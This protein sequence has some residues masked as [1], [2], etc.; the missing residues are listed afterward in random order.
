M[1]RTEQ[2]LGIASELSYARSTPALRGLA[3]SGRSGRLTWR[4]RDRF[5][6][7]VVY[8]H[9]TGEH[10]ESLT[11]QLLFRRSCF[12][13]S[14]PPFGKQRPSAIRRTP[15]ERRETSQ[16]TQ[17]RRV[18]SSFGWIRCSGPFACTERLKS[19]CTTITRPSIRRALTSPGAIWVRPREKRRHP[20][21]RPRIG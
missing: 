21:R 3:I 15:S 6:T 11:R 12:G 2:S 4:G 14:V 1:R 7:R 20:D 16:R 19:S 17:S 13:T 8:E 9:H 5:T 18:P 10:R